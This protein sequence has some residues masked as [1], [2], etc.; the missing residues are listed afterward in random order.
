MGSENNTKEYFQLYKNLKQLKSAV[1]LIDYRNVYNRIQE[2]GYN[3]IELNIFEKIKSYFDER[4]IKIIEFIAYANFDEKDFHVS[5]HQTFLQDMGITTKHTLNKGKN[6]S[7]IQLVVDALKILYKNKNVE[8]FII[9]SSERDMT[10]LFHAIEQEKKTT[11]WIT[12]RSELEQSLTNLSDNHLYLEN[13]L[14]IDKVKKSLQNEIS[15]K[16][17][18]AKDIEHSRDVITLLISSRIWEKF[19]K[20]GVPINFD[21]YKKHVAIAKKMIPDEVDKAFKI[22]EK[23]EWI[24]FYKFE[25]RNSLI[26]GVR[27][28]KKINDILKSNLYKNSLIN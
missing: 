8:I 26:N 22:A 20:D 23:M 16:K 5:Y 9:I 13:I 12:T 25:R 19:I 1:V 10:P 27:A 18:S 28:G 6:C 14:E 17:I 4:K 3:I 11:Y 7:D 15:G 21:E 24:E 2:S